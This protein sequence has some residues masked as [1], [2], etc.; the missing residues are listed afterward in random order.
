MPV[1]LDKVLRIGE[2]KQRRKLEAA[3]AQ[4]NAI[5]DDFVPMSDE[6]LQALTADYKQRYADGETLD[7]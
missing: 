7:E 6:E 4:V 5:E 2:G 3:A 1:L